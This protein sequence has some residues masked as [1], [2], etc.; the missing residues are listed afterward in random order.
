MGLFNL[1]NRK[2]QEKLQYDTFSTMLAIPRYEKDI[3]EP[4]VILQRLKEMAGIRIVS[5]ELED[6]KY[7]LVIEYREKE[8]QLLL[9]PDSFTLP[10]YYRQQHRFPDVEMDK[11][12]RAETGIMIEMLFGEDSLESYHL[13]LKIVNAILPDLLALID[14]SSEKILSGRWVA[15]AAASEVAPAP[16]YIYTVQAVSDD[17]QVWLHT[18]GLSRCGIPELEV[19]NSTTETSNNH[20]NI[21]ETAASRLLEQE[22]PLKPKEPL[23]LARL[24]E[25]IFM[26]ITVIPW[27]EAVKGY[28][29]DMLGGKRDR[30]ESHNRN[31]NAIFVYLSEED[32]K[33]KRY[34]PVSIY[35]EVLK[36]N[37]IF[38]I[39]TRETAR[40]RALAIERIDYVRKAL[41]KGENTILVK[42]GLVIDDEFKEDDNIHEHI[43]F[44]LKEFNGDT[45]TAELTQEPYYVKDMHTG[46]VGSYKIEEVTDWLIFTPEHRLSPDDAYLLAE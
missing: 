21:I 22:E 38:M 45:L 13:Q 36:D 9:Y 3:A 1:F 44:E 41:G 30:A 43:W 8:H 46:S 31:T 20:Y 28:P 23:Y 7:A 24:S 37:P 10:E 27:E 25:D 34:K 39:T 26:V 32:C 15:M 2:M 40:M 18:H 42:I 11:L 35:D 6:Y 19:L 14:I 16:R 33:K 29:L 12:V 5:S 17:D 4:D